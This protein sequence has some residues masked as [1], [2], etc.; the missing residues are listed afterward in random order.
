MQ[1]IYRMPRARLGNGGDQYGVSLGDLLTARPVG[2]EEHEAW[3]VLC[4]AVQA[5]QDLFLSGKV[6]VYVHC[7]NF[8]LISTITTII[9]CGNFCCTVLLYLC[10]PQLRILSPNAFLKAEK[11]D[12]KLI[13]CL[14]CLSGSSRFIILAQV[15]IVDVLHFSVCLLTVFCI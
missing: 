9:Q 8:F 6:V 15:G 4:Q 13:I 1:F 14:K 7:N 5:L 12:F 10:Q 3:A 2:L 11:N